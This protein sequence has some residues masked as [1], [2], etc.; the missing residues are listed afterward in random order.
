M[1]FWDFTDALVRQVRRHISLSGKWPYGVFGRDGTEALIQFGTCSVTLFDD[2]GTATAIIRIP[3][4]PE[5]T[6]ESSLS[7]QNA[8]E[9]GEE[10]GRILA[11]TNQ[12]KPST[13]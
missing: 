12:I 4:A 1:T 11:E 5:R 9:L 13:S 2:N 10:I 8:H 7:E 3:N 6:V